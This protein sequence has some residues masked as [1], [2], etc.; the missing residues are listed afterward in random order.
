[1]QL[2]LTIARTFQAGDLLFTMPR[3]EY[4]YVYVYICIYI[5][6][7]IRVYIYIYIYNCFIAYN[8]ILQIVSYRTITMY[9]QRYN[10]TRCNSILYYGQ[11][12]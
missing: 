5:Y 1:M 11:F 12:S 2:A 8:M 6:I 9:C 4:V 3:E 10:V 7:Y